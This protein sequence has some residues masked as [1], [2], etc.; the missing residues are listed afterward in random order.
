MKNVKKIFFIPVPTKTTDE[1]RL[2]EKSRREVETWVKTMQPHLNKNT[3]ILSSDTV[4]ATEIADILQSSFNIPLNFINELNDGNCSCL[5]EKNNE[6]ESERWLNMMKK[7]DDHGTE[8]F[9]FVTYLEQICTYYP[10][11]YEKMTGCDYEYWDIVTG[12]S[13]I[14]VENKTFL[15]YDSQE[16]KQVA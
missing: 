2:S 9:I 10:L 14:D 8:I 16:K 7:Y 1:G 12:L 11:F 13:L 15:I 4:A 5:N 3:Q 6:K